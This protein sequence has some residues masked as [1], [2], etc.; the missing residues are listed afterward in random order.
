MIYNKLLSLIENNS[1]VIA[2]KWKDEIKNSEYAETYKKLSDKELITRANNVY[3]NLGKWLDRDTTMKEIGDEY[4]KIGKARYKEGF[5]LCEVQLALHYTKKILWNHIIS[6]GILTNAL[7][8]FQALELIV[9]I[10][11]FFDI[12]SFYLIRGYQEA[13]YMEITKIKGLDKKKLME[14]F[15]SGSFFFEFNPDLY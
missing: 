10:Y 6:E 14:L 12:A 5:P 11:N 2:K 8:I 7:E 13:T 3:K 1:E 15:P 4:V 9:S